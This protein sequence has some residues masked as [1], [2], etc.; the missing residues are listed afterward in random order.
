MNTEEKREVY[1]VARRAVRDEIRA[2]ISDVV[3]MA[4]GSAL[5]VVGLLG[6]I[7]LAVRGELLTLQAGVSALIALLGFAM[8]AITWRWDRWLRRYVSSNES[9]ERS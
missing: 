4:I 5:L 6:T 7:G 8:V 1:E 2:M 9:V 3:A